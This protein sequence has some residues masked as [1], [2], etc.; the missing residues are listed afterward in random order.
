MVTKRWQEQNTKSAKTN[1]IIY[2]E[3]LVRNYKYTGH[4]PR[5]LKT[6]TEFDGI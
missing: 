4:C 6:I 3:I 2:K 5:N 1:K